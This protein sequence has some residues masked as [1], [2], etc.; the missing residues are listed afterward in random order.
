MKGDWLT[1]SAGDVNR[2][3]PLLLIKVCQDVADHH[4][5]NHNFARLANNFFQSRLG[6]GEQ[7]DGP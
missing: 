3:R 7:I 1:E 4:R 2:V 5:E 6:G